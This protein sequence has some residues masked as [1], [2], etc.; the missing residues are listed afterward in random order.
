MS[1]CCWE[2]NVCWHASDY[3]ASNTR[4][5]VWM[6]PKM[7]LWQFT[8]MHTLQTTKINA[9]GNL[10]KREISRNTSKDPVHSMGL[11]ILW[12]IGHRFDS[13]LPSSQGEKE[14]ISR[15]QF[16]VYPMKTDD[17]LSIAISGFKA[18]IN[19]TPRFSWRGH[20]RLYRYGSPW[21]SGCQKDSIKQS[22]TKYYYFR[23]RIARVKIDNSSELSER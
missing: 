18:W 2:V 15:Y 7:I 6:N 1:Q 9:Y 22:L 20:C 21:P 17:F 16:N 12:N 11:I 10:R 5:N 19:Y 23:G 4:T 13:K 14:D 8:N 3:L